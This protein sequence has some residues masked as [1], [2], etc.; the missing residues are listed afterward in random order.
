MNFKRLLSYIIPVKV[1]Q[2]PS[3]I[4]KNLEVTWNNGHLVL[5]SENTNFSFG[6]LQ[7]VMRI[8]LMQIE[9]IKLKKY[10]S[11]LVLGVAG[12]SV[13]RLLRDEFDYTE[14]ITGV[15]LDSKVIEI[16]NKYFNLNKIKNLEIKI[17]DAQEFIFTTTDDYD[18]IIIDI[19]QDNI[20]PSFLFEEKFSLQLKKILTEN[21][22]ILFNTIVTLSTDF[23]RNTNY[24]Q[25][26]KTHFTT[27]KI[28][29]VEGDNELFL[30]CK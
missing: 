22:S 1:F 12:G 15:E 24:Y 10:Q 11:V 17:Q 18:L 20:M 23:D 30:L 25:M 3:E 16:A 7:K 6:T 8:G 27:K 4:N 14:K 9:K 26:I 29:N 13:I 2:I 28:S 19:F 21:G 5:D